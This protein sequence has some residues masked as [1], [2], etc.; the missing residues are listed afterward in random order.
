MVEEGHDVI[1]VEPPEGDAVRR[2]GPYLGG[3]PN[4]ELGAFHLFLNA[5][6]RSLTLNLHSS[7]GRDVFMALVKTADAVIANVPLAVT[8]EE[9]AQG[10][11]ALVAVGV[12]DDA[13][14]ELCAYARSGLLA[15]T[16]HPGKR[17]ALLGGH[18]VYAAT[19]LYV[20]VA[21]SAALYGRRRTGR[22][23]IVTVSIR[24]C[25]ESLAE[26]SMISYAAEGKITQRRGYRGAITAISGAFPTSDGYWMAS[27][28]TTPGRWAE[29]MEWVKDPVLKADASLEDEAERLI[30]RDFILDRLEAWSRQFPKEHMVE[31]AQRRHIPGTPVA[32]ASDLA[33]DPQL[34]ARGFFEEKEHSETG[35][36]I[37][38][39]RG[40]IGVVRGT[41][42]GPAP[43]LGQH[44]AEILR[45]LGFSEAEHRAM[46]EASAV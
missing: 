21:A 13:G 18:I 25:L 6:K 17:P 1:R 38:S 16:G 32:V 5:G 26:Q 14:P 2:L 10:N 22:G 37:L 20:S 34:W 41:S 43:R 4:L 46:V 11:E 29:L 7:P 44:N 30:K 31:E 40:A 45:E 24:R 36:P 15:I 9:I 35:R 19:G 12:E 28:P 8:L 27:M 23:E 39:P 33:K 3:A 42:A